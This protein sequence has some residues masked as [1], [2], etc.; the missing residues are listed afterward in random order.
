MARRE[1]SKKQVGGNAGEL[2]RQDI[3]VSLL[4]YLLIVSAFPSQHDDAFALTEDELRE[5]A[6]K[7]PLLVKP[8]SLDS[9]K[10]E[11]DSERYKRKRQRNERW[12]AV[13]D[14]VV[15]AIPPAR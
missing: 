11:S 2:S 10:Q 1:T 4:N 12:G 6:D 8:A 3:V 14:A 7:A 5:N 15:E 9:S 13:F